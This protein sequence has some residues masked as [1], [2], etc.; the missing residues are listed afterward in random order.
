MG[1]SGSGESKLDEALREKREALEAY[2]DRCL[3]RETEEP[4]TL[5]RA[6][7]YSMFAGG[8]RIRPM[9]TL[10]ASEA[11]GGRVED[12]L[13]V[14]A[15]F[16]CIHAYSLIHDDLPCMD[17][18]DLRRGIPTSHKVFGV[19]MAVL[20]GDGLLTLA[21][22]LVVRE[23]RDSKRASRIVLE[24][25]R[26]AGVRGMV[27]GQAMDILSSGAGSDSGALEEMHRRKTQAL[28]AGA[29]RCGA[30]VGGA[31][32]ETVGVI[33]TYGEKV[34]LAF[35][36]MDDLLDEE[37]TTEEL[38]KTAGKD[39]SQDKLTYPRIFGKA[40]SRGRARTL[41]EEAKAALK[42][43]GSGTEILELLAEYVVQR[44]S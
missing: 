3:P 40:E 2:L 14:A 11:V 39:R 4:G 10:L 17:D 31:D 29:T 18:D 16:E 41:A 5:H 24:M 33:N 9:L 36:I 44:K 12:A 32:E 42:A 43:L 26:S 1:T 38:G 28:I 21:F 37:G 25:A 7:R 23:V 30:I 20:A 13:P 35:Q 8:K 27:G 34:G 6:I 19:G 15:A 22:E